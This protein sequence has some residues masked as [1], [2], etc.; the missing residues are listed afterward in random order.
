[1]NGV[2]FARKSTP[3]S[4]LSALTLDVSASRPRLGCDRCSWDLPASR[5]TSSGLYL[6][7]ALAILG[8]RSVVMGHCMPFPSFRSIWEAEFGVVME[9]LQED[10]EWKSRWE[11]RGQA[12]Q[13]ILGDTISPGSGTSFS[14]T[15]DILPGA[16]ALTFSPKLASDGFL[17]LTLGLTQPLRSTDKAFPWEISIRTNGLE[18]WPCDLL[19]QLL[20]QWLWEK[21][22]MGFG[23]HLPFVFFTD[24]G[25]K[26]WSGISDDVSELNVVGS[27]RGLYLWTDERH[28]SFKTSAGDFGLLAVVGVT[29]DEDRLAY[30]TTPAHLMLLLRRMGIS[31]I[32]DPYRRSVLSIPGATDQWRRIESMSDDDAFNVLQSMA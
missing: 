9:K 3:E 14:W 31:Q 1:M 21:G 4:T 12:V 7:L 28:L 8:A 29:E 17:Y 19:Y 5:E 30:S 16:C 24:R 15:D 27:I 26:L 13:Q 18:E 25:G 32:C 23:Y 2:P 20:T 6:S 10:F 22:D 11:E